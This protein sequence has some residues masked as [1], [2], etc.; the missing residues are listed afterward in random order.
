MTHFTSQTPPAVRSELSAYG[1]T[2]R[3]YYRRLAT[4][5]IRI[6]RYRTGA[7]AFAYEKIVCTADI[8]LLRVAANTGT[9]TWLEI[10]RSYK[11]AEKD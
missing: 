1:Y 8:F 6:I 7:D 2:T 10:P 11:K 9:D 5:N 3:N 4:E